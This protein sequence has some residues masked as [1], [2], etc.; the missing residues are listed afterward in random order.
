MKLL[1]IAGLFSALTINQA[2]AQVYYN[3]ADWDRLNESDRAAYIA[4][5]YDSLVSIATAE[6]ASSARHYSRCV[7]SRQLE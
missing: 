7:V 4:G 1:L 2:N 3:Y 6:T 5:A